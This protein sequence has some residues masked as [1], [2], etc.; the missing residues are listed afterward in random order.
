MSTP[1][2]WT[3]PEPVRPG[4]PGDLGFEP[5]EHAAGDP[6]GTVLRP[7]RG[8]P[9]A[10]PQGTS[11]PPGPPIPRS[12]S[13]HLALNHPAGGY[14]PQEEPAGDAFDPPTGNGY[15]PAYPYAPD[16]P[17]TYGSLTTAYGDTQP[18]AYGS[19]QAAYGYSQPPAFGSP[20]APAYGYSPSPAY[21]YPAPAGYGPVWG[22]APQATEALAIASLVTGLAGLL[23]MMGLPGIVAIGLGV[24]A[25]RNI[26]RKGTK[27]RGLAIAGIVVGGLSTLFLALMVFAILMDPEMGY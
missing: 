13:G 14:L 6:Y 26:A 2:T 17:P 23:V 3:R 11:V 22:A 24:A 9:Y 25:L 18:A 19:P 8:D 15:D 10:A 1:P 4:P 21:G 27:G 20:Q 5:D 16:R 7:G 12:P